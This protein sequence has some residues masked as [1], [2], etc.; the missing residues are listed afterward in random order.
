MAAIQ[1][2]RAALVAE[3]DTLAST[4]TREIGKPISQSRNELNG[5]LP[6]IDFFLAQTE[7][8]IADETV[9]D[10]GG[11][12]ERIEHVPLGVVANISAWNY[13]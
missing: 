3:L 9:F 5:L 4:L 6:R 11:M 8:A 7:A 10:D 1:R 13:P 12:R 2:F